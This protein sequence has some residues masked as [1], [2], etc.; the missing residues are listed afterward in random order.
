MPTTLLSLAYIHLWIWNESKTLHST[1]GAS[2][3]PAHHRVL[4]LSVSNE[5][6]PVVYA[7]PQI[8]RTIT[9]SKAFNAPVPNKE[10]PGRFVIRPVNH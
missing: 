3:F 1:G 4:L 10:E 7:L 5:T 8:T 2:E 6:E 9:V